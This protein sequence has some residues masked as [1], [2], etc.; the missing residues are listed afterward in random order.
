MAFAG[1]AGRRFWRR[2]LGDLAADRDIERAAAGAHDQGAAGRHRQFGAGISGRAI[3]GGGEDDRRLVGVERRRHPGIDP[4]AGRR[5]HAL[6][7]E[8]RG[9]PRTSFIAGSDEGRNQQQHHQRP[10]RH[11]I[12]LCQRR[13]RHTGAQPGE[14]GQ[15]AL[16]LRL[17]QRARHWVIG[18]EGILQ[19]GRR[20]MAQAAAAI[21]PAQR[22]AA[23]WPAQLRKRHQRRN[24][25]HEEQREPGQPAEHR[26]QLPQAR[27]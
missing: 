8:R 25:Q 23:A 21:K 26:Q 27:P 16:A 20:A 9:D 17:P 7:V 14:R 22:L 1:A 4:H 11:R 13:R 18:G 2:G 12:M 15:H 5:Q 3:L 19:R 24:N 6:P 10:Q